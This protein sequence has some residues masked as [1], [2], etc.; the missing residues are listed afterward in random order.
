[1]TTLRFEVPGEPRGKGRPRFVKKNGIAYT[2]KETAQYE[3]LIVLACRETMGDRAPLG[4]P[5]FLTVHA[6]FAIPPSKSKKWKARAAQGQ[7]PVVKRPD[8]DNILKVVCD[9]LNGVAWKDDKQVYFATTSKFYGLR[10][11]LS[12][13]INY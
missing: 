6:H 4:C 3:N 2:P 8:L 12:V 7:E 9:A 13:E 10:P 11:R 5:V 1:M